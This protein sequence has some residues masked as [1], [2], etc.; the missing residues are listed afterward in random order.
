MRRR[1]LLKEYQ[2]ER[3]RVGERDDEITGRKVGAGFG[4]GGDAN[5]RL[6]PTATANQ[7]ARP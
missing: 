1:G 7:E 6:C 4:F 3:W 5:G 2:W